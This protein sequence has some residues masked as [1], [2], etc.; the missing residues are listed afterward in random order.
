MGCEYLHASVVKVSSG[1]GLLPALARLQ[2]KL[3]SSSLFLWRRPRTHCLIHFV[4]FPCLLAS[5]AS[6]DR[7]RSLP[8]A[9]LR[10]LTVRASKAQTNTKA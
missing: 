3:C 10:Q 6:F 9:M 8:T 5:V 1:G 4:C 2:L 7:R